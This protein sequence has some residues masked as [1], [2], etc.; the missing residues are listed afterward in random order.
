M[1]VLITG[2]MDCYLFREGYIRTSSSPF[3]IDHKNVDD[4]F[5]HL[6]NNAVQ[7]HS[8]N[9]GCFEDGNQLSFAH[10]NDY[11]GGG[12]FE[13]TMVPQM[14][15][16][17][18][19]SLLSVR[20]KLNPRRS[21]AQFEIFGYDFMIDSDYHVWLIEVNTNPCLEESSSLLQ[22][23]M[24]RM[25]NDAFKLTLDRVFH[26][27]KK[28]DGEETNHPVKGYE[29]DYNMW[30]YHH[31][32]SRELLIKGLDGNAQIVASQTKIESASNAVCI[33]YCYTAI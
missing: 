30:Y 6:T 22:T 18:I 24:P 29:D 5:V 20:R 25:I 3:V 2:E 10:F 8:E 14:K 28:Y 12:I 23:F 33:H 15:Q 31:V 21:E 7:Q 27:P 19:R 9:Y 11:L 1:W 26:K 4:K 32:K 16:L 13:E 17:V